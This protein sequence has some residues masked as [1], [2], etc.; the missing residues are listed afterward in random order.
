[1]ATHGSTVEL[2]EF[3]VHRSA[4]QLKEADPHT[5]G[6]PRLDGRAKSAM[7][8]IQMDEY[9]LGEPG[10]S[11]AELFARTMQHCGLDARY[12][13]Y[14]DS[15][16]AATLATVNLVTMFGLHRRLLP[17]L[18]GHLALFEM[19]SV[20]PMGRY[21]AAL[22]RHGLPD[23]A[24]R[25]Y[26]VHVVAD[27]HHEQVA[28]RDLVAPFVEQRPGSAPEV[29]WGAEA[30]MAVEDHF[31][32]HLLGRWATGRSSLREPLPRPGRRS[33]ARGQATVDRRQPRQD[34][35]GDLRAAGELLQRAPTG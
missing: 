5:W 29:V 16:P 30:L 27:A 19:T 25:F 17:A 24:A 20:G 26:D 12:G 4:Y 13:R 28:A 23:D 3:V 11:H 2:M 14:L 7:V 1:M 15:L 31:T 10:E 35:P 32:R 33:S 22:R 9:G 34:H 18:V 8:E 6:L 21:A